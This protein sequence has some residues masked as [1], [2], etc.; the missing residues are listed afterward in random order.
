MSQ[1]RI[2]PDRGPIDKSAMGRADNGNILCR[3]CHEDTGSKRRTFCPKPK[4]CLHEHLMRSDPTYARKKVYAR[5]K[6]ICASC[7]LD[8]KELRE[9]C[10]KV[11]RGPDS[12]AK[13]RAEINAILESE[14]FPKIS[15][16]RRL[17]SLLL[18]KGWFVQADHI[19]A[20]KDGGGLCGLEGY[21]SLCRVCHLR[22]SV[23][24]RRKRSARNVIE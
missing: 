2:S 20:V 3:W 13:R 10:L 24:E 9:R 5:D 15:E 17:S 19:L 14:D 23:G 6:G 16:K 22:K 11:L 21:Q 12:A 8:T 18:S 7:S 4:P 1:E